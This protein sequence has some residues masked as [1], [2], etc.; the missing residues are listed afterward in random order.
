[1][2]RGR[3]EVFENKKLVVKKSWETQSYTINLRAVRDPVGPL[4][5]LTGHHYLVGT[6]LYYEIQYTYKKELLSFN[7]MWLDYNIVK[8]IQRFQSYCRGVISSD[9][10]VICL[11]Y[12]VFTIISKIVGSFPNILENCGEYRKK[13]CKKV[14]I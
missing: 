6:Y 12:G 14:S 13:T 2:G 11:F 9:F 4:Y 7:I 5:L 10:S 3:C 1:M 8:A